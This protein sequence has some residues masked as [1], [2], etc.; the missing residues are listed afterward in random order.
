M[1]GQEL[2]GKQGDGLD[3]LHLYFCT[4]M[5]DDLTVLS[6]LMEPAPRA[7]EVAPPRVKKL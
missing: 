1:S 4:A 3:K 2:V 5:G 6:N 7:A